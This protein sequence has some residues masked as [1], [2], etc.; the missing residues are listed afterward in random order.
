[1]LN[2]DLMSEDS[3]EDDSDRG[4]HDEDEPL[5]S[6][7]DSDD[8][9]LQQKIRNEKAGKDIESSGESD[10]EQEQ[11]GFVNPLLAAAQKKKQKIEGELSEGEWSDESDNVR[12]K[13]S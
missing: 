2:K 4:E 7:D 8:S 6:S 11:T 3:D 1:M 10:S 13:K 9:E 5:L 12:E